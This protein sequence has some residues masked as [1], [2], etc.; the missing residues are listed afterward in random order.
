MHACTII[1]RCV[2]S[3]ES[4]LWCVAFPCNHNLCVV[5]IQ[6]KNPAFRAYTKSHNSQFTIAFAGCCCC[7]GRKMIYRQRLKCN[8][9]LYMH[10]GGKGWGRC[11]WSLL[12]IKAAYIEKS[13]A[14]ANGTGRGVEPG[15]KTIPMRAGCWC[16]HHHE[17]SI[18]HTHTSQQQRTHTMANIFGITNCASKNAYRFIICFTRFHSKSIWC[19]SATKKPLFHCDLQ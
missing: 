9:S 17:K 7:C 13:T 11:G 10:Y 1:C 3:R 15:I 4:T 6:K 14:C 8:S 5:W 19:V 16:R 2:C 18:K 12:V